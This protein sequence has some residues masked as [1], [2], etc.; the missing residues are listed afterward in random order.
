MLTME[1]LLFEVDVSSLKATQID[2]LVARFKIKKRPHFKGGFSAQDRVVVANNGF[3]E[4]GEN[5]A[6]LFEWDGDAWRTLSQASHGV[7]GAPGYGQRLFCTGWDESSVLFWA[8]VNGTGR[9]Y[10]LPKA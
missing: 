4:F 1:G 3:Y 5:E 8:L 9:R 2:D 10:R 6:G 7:A